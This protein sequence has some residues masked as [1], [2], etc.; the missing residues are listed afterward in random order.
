MAQGAG[1]GRRALHP[2][3]C[4]WGG[5]EGEPCKRG[6]ALKAAVPYGPVRTTGGAQHAD[7]DGR[8]CNPLPL[9]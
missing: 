2:M 7:L 1:E 5:S 6:A 3:V 4:R 9:I 8:R